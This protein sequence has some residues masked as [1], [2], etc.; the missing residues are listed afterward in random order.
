MKNLVI[1]V[2]VSVGIFSPCY[3]SAQ[4]TLESHC[5][6]SCP[7]GAPDTN[8]QIVRS[9]Y[10]LSNNQETK[11]ADWVVYKVNEDNFD[12]G[13]VTRNFRL[14]PM[15]LETE[16]LKDSEYAHANVTLGTNKGH[17]APIGSF[18]DHDD[19]TDT[20]FLS[21]ITPQFAKLNQ[22]AWK[23][24]EEAIRDRARA[25]DDDVFVMTGPIYEWPMARLPDTDK[26]HRVPSAYWKIVV[27]DEAGTLKVAAFYF[28]QDTPKR[29]NYCDHMRTVD[30]IEAK[31]GLNFFESHDDEDTLDSTLP[32]LVTELGC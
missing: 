6:G 24:L 32:T 15:L 28:Y 23:E 14:D 19:G 9:V 4:V 18:K 17:Q 8:T 12:D 20:N 7:T 11:F 21:N 10:A 25:T 13:K 22:G 16:T 29:A 30:F 27:E 5:L 3:V 31:S 1:A 2:A 26:D